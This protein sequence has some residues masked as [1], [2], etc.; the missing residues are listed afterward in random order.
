MHTH[1]HTHTHTHSSTHTSTKPSRARKFFS[2][3]DLISNTKSKP[4]CVLPTLL[5][6]ILCHFPSTLCTPT[7]R[8]FSSVHH[9]PVNLG[10]HRYFASNHSGSHCFFSQPLPWLILWLTPTHPA[11]PNS[12]TI[13]LSKSSL[14]LYISSLCTVFSYTTLS[15]P[16]TINR[17]TFWLISA[18]NIKL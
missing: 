9:T 3:K 13:F 2:D 18:L 6:L 12:D 10:R 5:G 1:T 7:T 15:S 4:L 8:T 11:E 16:C 14:T 17:Y